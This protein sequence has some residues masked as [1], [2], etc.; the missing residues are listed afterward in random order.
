MAYNSSVHTG[1]MMSLTAS[2]GLTPAHLFLGRR[3]DLAI[4]AAAQSAETIEIKKPEQTAIEVQGNV[5]K[6]LSWMQQS[7]EKY[8]QQ[9]E[10]NVLNKIKKT[11]RQFDAGELVKLHKKIKNKT[12]KASPH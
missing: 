11:Q 8:E 4:H 9:M 7:R 12:I 3:I 6:A 10:T 1:K 2:D 5:L